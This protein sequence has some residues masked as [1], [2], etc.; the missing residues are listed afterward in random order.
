MPYRVE[1]IVRKRRYCMLH[2]ISPS[3]RIKIVE[4]FL[5]LGIIWQ[6]STQLFFLFFCNQHYLLFPQSM[7]M[8]SIRII[9]IN[10]VDCLLKCRLFLI[11]V[12]RNCQLFFCQKQRKQFA[13]FA[14]IR[15]LSDIKLNNT[16]KY[17]GW[18]T[19]PSLLITFLL[20]CRV[21]DER[22]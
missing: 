7:L 11:V 12:D 1:N 15:Q 17:L 22:L 20:L 9:D 10:F 5:I 21:I 8:L 19:R 2:S 18:K 6:R 16:S 13:E 4:I 3:N 14:W